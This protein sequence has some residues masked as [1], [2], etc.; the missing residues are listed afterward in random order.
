MCFRASHIVAYG[1]CAGLR[2]GENNIISASPEPSHAQA[3]SVQLFLI[4]QLG[5]NLVW[6]LEVL[7]CSCN[8]SLL[9]I[10]VCQSS[11]LHQWS[12]QA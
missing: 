1:S 11:D 9:P 8:A 4:A 6:Q 2:W 3:A 5:D 10:K 7:S 12:A